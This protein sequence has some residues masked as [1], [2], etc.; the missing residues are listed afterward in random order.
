M[1]NIALAVKAPEVPVQENL[2]D[3]ETISLGEFV[4][5]PKAEFSLQARVLASKRYRGGGAGNLAP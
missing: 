3:A 2:E 1:K 5:T 4:M